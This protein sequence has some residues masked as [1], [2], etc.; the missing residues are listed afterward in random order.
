[1]L[2]TFWKIQKSKLKLQKIHK[3]NTTHSKTKLPWFSRFLRHSTRKRG[4]LIL[5]CSR[6]HMGQCHLSND[7]WDVKW[8]VKPYLTRM[9]FG[10]AIVHVLRLQWAGAV[11]A[12]LCRQAVWGWLWSYSP[13]GRYCRPSW[14]CEIC[15]IEGSTVH[16]RLGYYRKDA[17][18]L[19]HWKPLTF[20]SF[21]PHFWNW[22]VTI[23]TKCG[24]A[25]GSLT[26]RCWRWC[27]FSTML[28]CWVPLVAT[29]ENL[30]TAPIWA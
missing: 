11:P 16:R 12:T 20:L 27:G 9:I 8:D 22:N 21:L 28:A 15:S 24:L 10:I 5:Q 4:G 18:R 2:Q 13:W 7:L 30:S 19:V 14:C 26:N 6:A 3:L 17:P 25:F 23:N 29:L 1:M